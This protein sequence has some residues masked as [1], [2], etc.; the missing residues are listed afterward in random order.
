[1]VV[2]MS[3]EHYGTIINPDSD[4]ERAY[5]FFMGPEYKVDIALRIKRL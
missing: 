5:K 3:A 1:M 4:F 2:A